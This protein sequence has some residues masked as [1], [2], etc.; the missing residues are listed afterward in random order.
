[1]AVRPSNNGADV[2]PA[3]ALLQDE[4]RDEE[5]LPVYDVTPPRTARSQQPSEALTPLTNIRQLLNDSSDE[6]EERLEVYNVTLPR[7][8][9]SQLLSEPASA[10]SFS[11]LFSPGS[12]T[13]LG[14]SS[15]GSA[16]SQLS[17]ALLEAGDF[18]D[19]LLSGDG[20]EAF[21]PLPELTAAAPSPAQLVTAPLAMACSPTSGLFQPWTVG[22]TPTSGAILFTHRDHSRS[23]ADLHSPAEHVGSLLTSQQKFHRTVA[24]RRRVAPLT[25]DRLAG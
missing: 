11:R 4:S 15:P 12:P 16:M 23:D 1:M 24:A 20:L 17:L 14:L 25:N 10:S 13:S 3:E 7:K 8:A 18:D 21:S 6:D 22:L 9:P 19:F 2:Q 5:E